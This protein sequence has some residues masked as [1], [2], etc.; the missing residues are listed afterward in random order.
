M[1]GANSRLAATGVR[2]VACVLARFPGQILHSYF[3]CAAG[4][5]AYVRFNHTRPGHHG[6][7]FIS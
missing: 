2:A 5:S 4:A 6:E 7:E 1:R 3:G